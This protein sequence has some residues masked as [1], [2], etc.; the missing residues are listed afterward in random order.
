M[1]PTPCEASNGARQVGCLARRG[2][3]AVPRLIPAFR[4]DIRIPASTR[5]SM[6]IRHPIATAALA[7]LAAAAGCAPA[8]LPP[9][10]APAPAADASAPLYGA[11]LGG[12]TWPITTA[13]PEAQTYFDEGVKLMYAYARAHARP[14]FAEARRRDPACAMCWWGE[15][16]SMGRYLNGQMDGAD[17]PAAHAAAGRALALAS[18][19][20]PIERDLIAAMTAR[21]EPE[22][23]A[24]GR[25]RLDSA[26][27]AAMAEV[28]E[29]HP[30]SHEAAAL[31]ADALMLLEPRRGTWDVGKPSVARIHQVLE[32]ALARD[33]SHPGVCHAYIHATE[34]T[35]RAGN[36]QACAD[37]LG[38][39]IPGA[40]HLNHMPSHTYNV[41]GRWGDAVRSNQVARETDRRAARGVAVSGYPAHNLH[42]LLFAAA[43]DGQREVAEEA[44][45]EMAGMMPDAVSLQAL[46]HLRFGGWGDVLALERTPENA[47][48]R[49]LWAFARGYAHLRTGAADSAAAYL[50]RVD[51]LA[52]AHPGI[53]FRGH[54]AA[55]LLGIT[56]GILRGETARAEG[57]TDEAIAAF[58][59]AVRLED[60]LVYDEPEPLPFAARDWLGAA[61][62]EA[63]RPAEAERVYREALGDR[64]NNGW[65]LVG[66]EDALRRQ[67]KDAEADRTRDAFR[68]SWERAGAPIPASRF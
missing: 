32:R 54:T 45:R 53:A 41:V 21:Y 16:W 48:H 50:A 7:L 9:P 8:A 29:R 17:A 42:M 67:G 23:T 46:V 30:D 4:A 25:L 62:L 51:S 6:N 61:L 11:A 1:P 60:A 37:L 26:Y 27:A 10:A 43:V 35:P 58:G 24:A 55:A 14:A 15:A 20:T 18:G 13:S 52:A 49:G 12:Y 34:T 44:A 40:S 39:A 66:L 19:A 64:P 38:S 2:L 63:G 5:P 47:L 59:E 28:Y 36:A 33:L 22:H 65:S 68:R 56:G 57:R 31:Y 3:R